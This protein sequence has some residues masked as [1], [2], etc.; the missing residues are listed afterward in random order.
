MTCRSSDGR[1]TGN[2]VA[3]AFAV[4]AFFAVLGDVQTGELDFVSRSQSHYHFDC[5]SNDEC[6]DNSQHECNTDG[7]NLFDP[8]PAVGN[9]LREAIGFGCRARLG[10][11]RI[12]AVYGGENACQ[13][14]AD[15]SADGVNAE[16]IQRVI[17]PKPGF[18]FPASE[19]R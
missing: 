15:G 1:V 10:D 5:V 14:S 16:G 8:K 4:I 6:A 19:V 3:A 13:E 11:V 17:V 7:F 18:D 9:E 2:N 12:A